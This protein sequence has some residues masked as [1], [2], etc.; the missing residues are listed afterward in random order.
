M[1]L[2]R[3]FPTFTAEV[4]AVFDL[5]PSASSIC[6]IWS[7]FLFIFKALSRHWGPVLCSMEGVGVELAALLVF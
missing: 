6:S 1:I 3:G 4:V 2:V 5:P 7:V